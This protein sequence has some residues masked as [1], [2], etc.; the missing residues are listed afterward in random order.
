MVGGGGFHAHDEGTTTAAGH[1][2]AR[3]EGGLDEDGIGAFQLLAHLGD[4]LLCGGM[5]VIHVYSTLPCTSVTQREKE[6]Y[7]WKR[8]GL[9]H[10]AVQKVQQLGDDLCVG[11]GDKHG[12]LLDLRNTGVSEDTLGVVHVR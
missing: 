1:Q 10:L 9:W 8:Q 12:T 2:L 11:V 3:V 4:Q 6:Q 7:L 5:G